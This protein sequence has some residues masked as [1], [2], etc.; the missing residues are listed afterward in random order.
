MN[1]VPGF[2]KVSDAC[3]LSEWVNEDDM[4]LE[5]IM[6]AAELE[7]QKATQRLQSR[8]RAKL[9]ED[10]ETKA[11]M[12]EWRLNDKAFDAPQPSAIVAPPP[13]LANGLGPVLHMRSGGSLRS[14]SPSHFRG[15]GASAGKLVMQVS[16][17]VV[18]PSEMGATSMAILRRMAMAGMEGM[19]AQAMRAMSLEDITG[20]E[21]E[22]LSVDHRDAGFAQSLDG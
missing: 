13:P 18:V 1:I 4:E 2:F 6:E 14:M 17:P 9:L 12:Q 15:G 8:A 5:A 20:K 10:E 7:L 21:V 19:G 3:F 22:Q 11:L 16:N